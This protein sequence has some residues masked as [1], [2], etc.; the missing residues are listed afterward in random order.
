VH[1]AAQTVEEYYTLFNRKD[2]PGIAGMFDLPAML[3]VGPRKIIL[4]KPDAVTALYQSLG[5][6]FASEGAVRLSWD[7]G[8]FT[9]IQVHDDLAVVKTVVTREGI[10]RAAVK[11]W[12]CSY[13]VRLDGNIWRFT[14][15]T[16]DDAGNARAV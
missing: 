9:V 16:S 13:T 7:R 6:K 15:V 11:T 3:L 1:P 4:D 2:W 10:D 14:V 12:N 8:S 5:D